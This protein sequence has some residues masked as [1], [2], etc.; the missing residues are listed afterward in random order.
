MTWLACRFERVLNV[1]NVLNRRTA[2]LPPATVPAHA[3]AAAGAAFGSWTAG[4]ADRQNNF[5][6]SPSV[7]HQ[8]A[9]RLRAVQPARSCT[10]PRSPN[11]W[12]SVACSTAKVCV[13]HVRTAPSATAWF[14]S[15]PCHG[16]MGKCSAS[17]H[18]L[19]SAPR[20]AGA[21]P[22]A[23]PFGCAPLPRHLCCIQR[24]QSGKGFSIR[25][26][27]SRSKAAFS[28]SVLFVVH[29]QD[30]VFGAQERTRTSTELPAST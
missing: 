18:T 13:M 30:F 27:K 28:K 17:C 15:R 22:S 10:R 16:L 14:P 20:G 9:S 2:R 24:A 4:A 25:Q 6:S 5:S 8:A 11:R 26:E 23:T 3:G 29:N 12:S 21:A 19:S 7:C 1:L